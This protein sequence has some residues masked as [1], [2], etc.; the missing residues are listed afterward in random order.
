M[1]HLAP[2]PE[3]ISLNCILGLFSWNFCQSGRPQ[4][5]TRGSIRKRVEAQTQIQSS[6]IGKIACKITFTFSSVNLE[7]IFMMATSENANKEIEESKSHP[8]PHTEVTTVKILVNNLMLLFLSL[9]LVFI[10]KIASNCAKILAYF[11]SA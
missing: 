9:Y 3:Q 1:E 6:S 7:F 4:G 5:G 8:G 2:L 11:F 10:M